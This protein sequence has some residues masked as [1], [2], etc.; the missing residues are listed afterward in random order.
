M[1][2]LGLLILSFAIVFSALF[3]GYNMALD[4]TSLDAG[5]QAV[6]DGLTAVAEAIANPPASLS[7]AQA[8]L[9]DTGAKL[10]AFASQLTDMKSAE[11]T[12]DAG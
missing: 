10:Q 12:E 7:E 8:A 4:R 2:T 11:D 9:D 6:A 3:K 1:I 5:L